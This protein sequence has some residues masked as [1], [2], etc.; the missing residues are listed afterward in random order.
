MTDRK[1]LKLGHV[2]KTLLLPL[3]GR[4]EET[5]KQKPLLV[6]QTAVDIID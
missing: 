3:W 2:Q 6:D 5:K 1:Y 4:A